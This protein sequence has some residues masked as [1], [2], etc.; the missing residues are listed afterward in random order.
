MGHTSHVT[1]QQSSRPWRVRLSQR[2]NHGSLHQH[3]TTTTT[4]TTTMATITNI[5]PGTNETRRE[6]GCW[7]ERAQTTSDVSFGHPVSFFFFKYLCLF[8]LLKYVYWYYMY[9]RGTDGL[10][11]GYDER[12]GPNDARRVVWAP[13]VFFF[14]IIR[15]SSLLNYVYRY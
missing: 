4:T 15:F 1:A 12:T 5:N 6:S 8:S 2:D 7:R 10:M 14:L 3:T 11:E 13:G 9:C